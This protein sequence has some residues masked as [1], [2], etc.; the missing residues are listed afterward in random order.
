MR[1][2]A[3]P[4]VAIHAMEIR[5]N[6]DG[7]SLDGQVQAMLDLFKAKLAMLGRVYDVPDVDALKEDE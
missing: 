3:V 2:V 4:G 6:L 1:S 5:L 7:K